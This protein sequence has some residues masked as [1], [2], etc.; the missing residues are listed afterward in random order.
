MKA[1]VSS[2]HSSR[3]AGIEENAWAVTEGSRMPSDCCLTK[4]IK[5]YNKRKTFSI[6]FRKQSLIDLN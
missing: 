4:L 6:H 5:T 3:S 2:R 1:G